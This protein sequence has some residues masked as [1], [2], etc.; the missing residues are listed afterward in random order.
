[1]FKKYTKMF[2]LVEE[3]LVFLFANYVSKIQL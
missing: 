1:V 2:L 3:T